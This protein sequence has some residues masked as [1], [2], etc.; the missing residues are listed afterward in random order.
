MLQEGRVHG[1]APTVC[2]HDVDGCAD[3]FPPGLAD[4]VEQLVTLIQ[5]VV[6]LASHM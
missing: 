6:R 1:Y 4:T 3:L 2:M 5:P